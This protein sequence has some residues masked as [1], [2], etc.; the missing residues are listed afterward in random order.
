MSDLATMLINDTIAER[1]I[2]IAKRALNK[3]LTIEDVVELTDL[4]I[5]TI[6]RLKEELDNR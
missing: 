6:Q 1:D 3:G 4:D 2:E 5:D